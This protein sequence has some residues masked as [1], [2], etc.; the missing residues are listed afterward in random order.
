MLQNSKI[1]SFLL[2]DKNAKK[3]CVDKK[4]NY[5]HPCEMYYKKTL[6]VKSIVYS[7]P[8][9]K[10][11]QSEM[12]TIL[13]MVFP[14]LSDFYSVIQF[15]RIC[16]ASYSIVHQW[17]HFWNIP[18][19]MNLNNENIHLEVGNVE[20]FK[21]QGQEFAKWVLIFLS[22]MDNPDG[23]HLYT[24]S[25]VK[26]M[27]NHHF[28]TAP[29]PNHLPLHLLYPVKEYFDQYLHL[30]IFYCFS[31]NQIHDRALFHPLFKN[32]SID[33]FLIVSRDAKRNND[34]INEQVLELYKSLKQYYKDKKHKFITI[35]DEY[36]TGVYPS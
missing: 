12:K 17:T 7:K 26:K 18:M 21:G 11:C 24:P 13:E 33:I 32:G 3:D 28:N 35:W 34:G 19:Y 10:I 15:R 14:F 27:L 1:N 36:T 25:F 5:F 8:I 30:S 4:F 20:C 22:H 23:I 6:P 9:Y 29:F 16:K 2:N 31:K